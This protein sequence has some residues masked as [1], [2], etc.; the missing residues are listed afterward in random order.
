M[1]S[2]PLELVRQNILPLLDPH[3]VACLGSTSTAMRRVIDDSDVWQAQWQRLLPKTQTV[4]AISVHVDEEGLQCAPTWDRCGRFYGSGGRHRRARWVQL[5]RPCTQLHHYDPSTLAP[6]D[7]RLWRLDEAIDYRHLVVQTI[8]DNL[9]SHIY[10]PSMARR[11]RRNEHA[12][13]GLE[14]RLRVVKEEQRCLQ[15]KRDEMLRVADLF[16][17][18]LL[19]SVPPSVV[20]HV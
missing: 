14:R 16:D 10:T 8:R 17:G 9:T 1:E 19:C 6:D 15:S 13:Y 11:T 3:E 2:L 4:T 12:I 5:G 20:H 7:A 18:Y